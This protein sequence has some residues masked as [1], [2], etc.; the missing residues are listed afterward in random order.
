MFCD[1]WN[2]AYHLTLVGTHKSHTCMYYYMKLPNQLAVEQWNYAT[3]TV[4]KLLSTFYNV[5]RDGAEQSMD[6]SHCKNSKAEYVAHHTGMYS[7]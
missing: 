4:A 2:F 5:I 6:T 7:N 1:T 3:R